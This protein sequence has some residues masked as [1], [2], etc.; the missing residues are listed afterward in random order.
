[1]NSIPTDLTILEKEVKRIIKLRFIT[2]LVIT[3][4]LGGLSVWY[5]L[6]LLGKEESFTVL[7]WILIGV[8]VL[9][10]SVTFIEAFNMRRVRS[11]Y[12]YVN[13]FIWNIFSQI[14]HLSAQSRLRGARNQTISSAFRLRLGDAI[15]GMED[16][17]LA[18]YSVERAEKN[19]RN[20]YVVDYYIEHRDKNNQATNVTVQR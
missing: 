12:A 20:T 6:Y 3:L 14:Q 17:D 18:K 13:F 4:L 5:H 16:Q 7:T 10:A 8:T 19:T 2:S 1:M 15:Q 11:W 9:A